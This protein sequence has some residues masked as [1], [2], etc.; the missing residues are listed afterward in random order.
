MSWSKKPLFDYK[1]DGTIAAAA[2]KYINLPVVKGMV[3]CYVAWIDATSSATVTVELT[4]F[5]G[6]EAPIE[7]AGTYQWKDSGVSFTGPAGSAAG[8]LMI[9]IENVR[10]SRARLKVVGAATTSL[11]VYNGDHPQ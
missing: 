6:E 1:A 4:S 5:P 7:T 9:N 3:G 10:Q 2:T 11:I 8:S